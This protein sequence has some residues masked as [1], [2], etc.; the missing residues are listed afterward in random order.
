LCGKGFGNTSSKLQ[1]VSVERSS[2]T[3]F[4]HPN[5]IVLATMA[6]EAARSVRRSHAL[7]RSLAA[8][9]L[10]PWLALVDATVPDLTD[11]ER[12]RLAGIAQRCLGPGH[13]TDEPEPE[14]GVD[15]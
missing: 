5:S 2:V 13:P 7:R 10:R 11:T 15:R 6:R 14:R 1:V 12:L 9:G 8:S 3:R 4:V